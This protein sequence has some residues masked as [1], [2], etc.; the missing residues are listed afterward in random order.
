MNASVKI[1]VDIA[2]AFCAFEITFVTWCLRSYPYKSNYYV[3]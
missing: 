1:F 3:L 2:E